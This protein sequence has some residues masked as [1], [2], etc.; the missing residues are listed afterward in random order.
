VPKPAHADAL[1]L[2]DAF[3]AV[4]LFRDFPLSR[5]KEIL[6]LA[7]RVRYPKGAKIIAQ[8]TAGQHF[9]IIASGSVSVV[10]DD[11]PIKTYQAGDYFGETAILLDQLR[12]ADVIARTEVEL[13]ELDRHGFLYL[14]RGTDVARRLTRLAH[15]RAERSFRALQKNSALRSLSSAQK[16]Q[17][18]SYLEPRQLKSG[19][20]LWRAG[21]LAEE[22]VLVDDARLALDGAGG[23]GEPF[24][25]GAFLGEIEA[26]RQGI[27]HLTTARAI[28]D[29][30]VFRVGRTDL[31]R[32]FQDN[33]GV[34]V[35]FLGTSFVE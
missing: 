24:G 32:F 33:P 26:L 11:Q 20:L 6:H 28:E 18:M 8:G 3:C 15:V 21:D 19:D 4:D 16:T 25:L 10:Q 17:L 30:R 23:N 34:L 1:A 5:A 9:Y 22:A 31:L 27:A 29:G 14:L 13:V 7:R 2:L 35:S 12:N